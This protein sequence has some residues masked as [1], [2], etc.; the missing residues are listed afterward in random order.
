MAFG[1]GLRPYAIAGRP[2]ATKRFSP[3]VAGLAADVGQETRLRVVPQTTSRPHL[4]VGRNTA[5]VGAV[6]GKTADT[7]TIVLT[8]KATRSRHVPQGIAPPLLEEGLPATR[9]S[10]RHTAPL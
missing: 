5:C 9:L 7:A 8:A 6:V 4:I 10:L 3:A 2:A 1:L